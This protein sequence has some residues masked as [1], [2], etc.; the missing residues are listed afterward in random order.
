[1]YPEGEAIRR[2]IKWISEQ[3][4]SGTEANINKLIN[5]AILKFDLSPK[6]AEF[7]YRFYLE[8]DSK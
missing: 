7:L 6:D 5:E 3:L 4:Q 1:M 8:K 2:A